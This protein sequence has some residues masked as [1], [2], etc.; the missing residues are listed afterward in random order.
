MNKISFHHP[1]IENDKRISYFTPAG[2]AYQKLI[3]DMITEIFIGEQYKRGKVKK[4]MVIMD[5]GA[6]IGLASLYFKDWA[7]V[8]Y[9]LEP[10]PRNYE[11]LVE[12]TKAY[13][14]IKPFNVGLVARSSTEELRSGEPYPI[15][16][17]LFG[18]GPVKTSVNL[19][20]IEQFMNE[21]KIEHV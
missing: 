13:P 6:N 4:D 10:N 20:S 1:K 21:Q 9:A 7:K 16:E 19:V 8:I 18:E 11:C 3:T 14:H 17:S 15:A 2:S 12:N 5:V